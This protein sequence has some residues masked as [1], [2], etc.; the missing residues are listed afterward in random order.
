M[1]SYVR[2]LFLGFGFFSVCVCV[3][4]S[5]LFVPL[6]EKRFLT[7]QGIVFDHPKTPQ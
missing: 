3:C 6:H 5:P 2:F 4:V 7:T 1:I